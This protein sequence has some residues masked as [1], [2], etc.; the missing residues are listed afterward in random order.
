M[1]KKILI[2]ISIVVA[3]FIVW[4]LY[5]LF[6]ATPASPKGTAEITS[7]DLSVNVTY[8]RPYKKGRLIFGEESA[9]ALQPYGQYWRLGANA[10]TEITVNKDVS[11]AGEA[12]EAGTYRMYVV[13]GATEWEVSL[14]SETGVFFGAAE[15]NYELD[16]LKVKVPVQTAP[17][18]EQFTISFEPDS[19]GVNMNFVWDTSKVTVPITPQ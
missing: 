4:S 6:F 3:A 10:A 1:K 2:G 13:P 18:L 12:V 9:G 17:E 19:T 11:F 15:P 14:N 5:G 8:S 7:G 16:V